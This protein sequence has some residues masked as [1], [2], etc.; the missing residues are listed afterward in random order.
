ML[1]LRDALGFPGMAVLQFAFDPDDTEHG[2]HEPDN[3]VEHQAVYTGT[4]DSD[5]VVGWWGEL[6]APRRANARAAFSDA[7]AGGQLGDD[8]PGLGGAVAAGHDPGPGHPR[9]GLGGAA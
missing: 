4:H 8:P 7:D 2:T 5:T 3:L 9:P 6:E 1:E